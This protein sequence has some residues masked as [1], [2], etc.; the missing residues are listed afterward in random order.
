MIPLLLITCLLGLT[1]AACVPW[2]R[3]VCW[4][5]D[6]L[7]RREKRVIDDDFDA[8]A[9][10]ELQRE[11]ERRPGVIVAGNPDDLFQFLPPAGNYSAAVM[12]LRIVKI[13]AER[14]AQ[15]LGVRPPRP[16]DPGKLYS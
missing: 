4:L 10:S 16:A 1:L 6:E 15:A 8:D 13:D 12:D 7:R 14:Y 11:L 5:I 2:W 3:E 9:M